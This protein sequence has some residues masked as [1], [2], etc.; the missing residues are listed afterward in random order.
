MPVV[1]GKSV[2][3]RGVLI[4]SCVA[5][6]AHLCFHSYA[7]NLKAG[8]ELRYEGTVETRTTYKSEPPS[9][10][11][12]RLTLIMLV[13]SNMM[14][15]KTEVVQIRAWKAEQGDAFRHTH[16]HIGSVS[17]DGKFMPAPYLE[18]LPL[19]FVPMNLRLKRIWGAE[20]PL[21]A[22]IFTDLIRSKVMHYVIGQSE[23]DG[24][25]CWLLVRHLPKPFKVVHESSGAS[26]IVSMW[27][28]WF[29]V[30]TQTGLVRKWK[31]RWKY[32]AA[33]SP[34]RYVS[35]QT[36][37]ISLK[38]VKVLDAKTLQQIRADFQLLRD[39]QSTLEKL[40]ETREKLEQAEKFIAQVH[41]RL[42]EN[43]YATF[44]EPYLNYWNITVQAW[45]RHMEAKKLVGKSAPDFELPTIDGKGKIKLS[46]LRG[47]VIL[48][49]FFSHW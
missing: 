42:R 25:Q 40:E 44:L 23:V 49:D 32:V 13:L 46:D 34:D 15:T 3:V 38:Q 26:Y 47:K 30:D 39:L 16:V 24:S 48:L 1:K 11:S 20:E 22:G 41:E 33:D 5:L 4:F 12:Q 9:S 2:K 31:R 6:S 27:T 17:K 19:L 29:W 43:P 10:Y 28:D 7:M 37:E 8:L 21:V 45:K 35:T 14:E 18:E 36:L